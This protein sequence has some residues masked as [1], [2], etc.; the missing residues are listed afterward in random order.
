M[1]AHN[2]ME[3]T[4][5]QLKMTKFFPISANADPLR[6]WRRALTVKAIS[7]VSGRDVGQTAERLYG[8]DIGAAIVKAAT[9]PADTANPDWAGALAGTIMGPFLRILR[10]RSA[11]AQLIALGQRYDLSGGSINLPKLSS[12]YPNMAWIG[13]AAPVPVLQGSLTSTTLTP[14]KLMALSALTNELADRSAEEAEGIISDLLTTSAGRA[15]DLKMFSADAATAVAPAGLFNGLAATAGAAGGGQTALATDLRALT[16]A[17][18][19]A[20]GGGNLVVIASPAQAM[21][22]QVLGSGGFTTPV[23][24]APTLA[25]GTVAVL[26]ANAFVSGFG[27][28]PKIEVAESAVIHLDD[29]APASIGT[30]GAP[31]TVSAPV[32]SAFQA[33]FK[34][35]RCSLQAA[36]ALRSPALAYTT[37]ATW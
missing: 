21:S 24:V 19:A 30:A 6:N 15:L 13:E 25:A 22:I 7:G 29:A 28:D 34:V 12:E 1:L 5:E 9:A 27:A 3:A 31:N 8:E 2:G 35:L 20:G 23:I 11:A 10:P 17:V 32:R 36:F 4:A 37:S 26:D 33:D 14:K 16:A 18:A